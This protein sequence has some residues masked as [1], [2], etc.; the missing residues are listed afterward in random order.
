[1]NEQIN[2][3][4]ADNS[5]KVLDSTARNKESIPEFSPKEPAHNPIGAII[6]SVVLFVLL[7]VGGLYLYGSQ[8]NNSKADE[9]VN[10][11]DN[12]SAAGDIESESRK[13]NST[14]E[15]PEALEDPEDIGIE[16]ENELRA[17]SA[18]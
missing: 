16:P 10:E 15:E 3:P 12:D 5:R 4:D 6:G 11:N 14:Q 18:E 9:T 7:V 8:L 17:D 1:M 13:L 2:K